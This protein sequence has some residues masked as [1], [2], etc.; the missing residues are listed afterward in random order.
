[1][2]YIHIAYPESTLT[3]HLGNLTQPYHKY[4]AIAAMQHGHAGAHPA[5]PINIYA[6]AASRYCNRHTSL[7]ST[8]FLQEGR[9]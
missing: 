1:M 8:L 4:M 7:N 3:D 9:R 2:G 5:P 6:D